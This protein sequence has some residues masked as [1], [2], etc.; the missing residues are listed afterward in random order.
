MRPVFRRGDGGED[1]AREAGAAADVEDE[2]GGFEVEEFEGAVGHLRLDG[3]DAGGGGVFA[4]FG[5]VVEE[6]WGTAGKGVGQ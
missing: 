2:G 1:L 5:V 4:G 3:L 6:V